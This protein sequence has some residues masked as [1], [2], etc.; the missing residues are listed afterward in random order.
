[1]RWLEVVQPLST[2]GMDEG[3][4]G[5][6]LSHTHCTRTNTQ[7]HTHTHTHTHTSYLLTGGGGTAGA[8]ADVEAFRLEDPEGAAGAVGAAD[9]GDS[10]MYF[11]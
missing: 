10:G 4:A 3:R 11:L 1:M 8:D 5:G 9:F 7:T 2:N 6:R